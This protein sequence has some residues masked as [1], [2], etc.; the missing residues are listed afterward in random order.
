MIDDI[1]RTVLLDPEF[2]YNYVV[3]TAVYVGPRVRFIPSA[4]TE[5]S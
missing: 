4:L 5:N 1:H 3:H 2:P